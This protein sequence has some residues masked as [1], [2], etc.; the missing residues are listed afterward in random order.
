MFD[1]DK[2]DFYKQFCLEI[3]KKTHDFGGIFE[4]FRKRKSQISVFFSNS[5][6]KRNKMISK[7]MRG[8]T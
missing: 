6:C 5:F 3:T 8:I 4:I 2:Y 7:N 1:F